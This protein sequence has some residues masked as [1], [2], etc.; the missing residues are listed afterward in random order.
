LTSDRDGLGLLDHHAPNGGY[1]RQ[2]AP[3][4]GLPDTSA[5]GRGASFA[6]AAVTLKEASVESP[7]SVSCGD[8]SFGYPASVGGKK[9][10]VSSPTTYFVRV[11][12]DELRAAH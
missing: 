5:F 6:L 9:P 12:L 4:G 10:P 1:L 7:I 3:S 2:T 11:E 8:S